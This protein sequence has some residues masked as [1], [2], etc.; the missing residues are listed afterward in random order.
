L[1]SPA[2]EVEHV[3]VLHDQ[4]V[5][6]EAERCVHV[7]DDRIAG[8]GEGVV[9]PPMRRTPVTVGLMVEQ[10]DPQIG[11]LT[12]QHAPHPARFARIQRAKH[13][14][15]EARDGRIASGHPLS[16]ALGKRAVELLNQL[17]GR[18]RH[19]DHPTDPAPTAGSTG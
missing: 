7:V 19:A 10:L 8:L 6:S 14:V 13:R 2:V 12:G 17:F 15:G 11:R 9:R 3:N 18:C 1:A 5:V 16:G 4:P